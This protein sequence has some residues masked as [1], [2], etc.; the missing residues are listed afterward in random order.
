[1]T[2]RSCARP[3]RRCA[4][5]LGLLSL[6][7]FAP[8]A[9]GSDAPGSLPPHR[10]SASPTPT[11]AGV[12]ASI[13][14]AKCESCHRP[15]QVAPFSL[16]TYKQA[17]AWARD[18]KTYTQSRTMPPWKPVVGY[19]HFADEKELNLTDAERATIAR[20][21]DAGAPPG[22]PA[23]IPPPR[24]FASGWFL[25]EPDVVLTPDRP[26][27]VAADGEDVYRNFI[28]PTN[29][30]EGRYVT[31]AEIQ[32]S[33]RSIVHHCILYVDAMGL[34]K[35]MKASD[36][37]E[38]GY[39]SFG[40]PGFLPTG[41]L[42]GWA[43][44]MNPHW[45]PEGVA[46]YLAKGAAIVLQV[47]YHKNGKPGTD[48]TRI[49]LHFARKPIDKRI[50]PMVLINPAIAI[51]PGESHFVAHATTLI[52]EDSHLVTMM[53]H[54]HFLGREMKIWATLPDGTEKPVIWVR[55]WDFNWQP[56][57]Y[58]NPQ[59]AL[60]AGSHL[61]LVAY[62][63]NSTS[64]PYNPNRASP[65]LVTFGE[66]TTDEMCTGF[67]QVTYDA[68]HLASRSAPPHAASMR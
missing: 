52:P 13:F 36:D 3:W 21:V 45:T 31:A 51:P 41:F 50:H 67:F 53:P 56:T 20:W 62:Y 46:M 17:V 9:R 5:A 30:P 38:P 48:L 6:A 32:P 1:M 14:R 42:G 23:K 22:D 44:G 25:G 19:G 57:Y 64:N 54:M 2:G 34:T 35:M 55:N 40:G 63:D 47:H 49:G 60:P 12:V 29:F 61:S 68:E 8:S 28:I 37:G 58:L 33:N 66:A 26:Y 65:K 7:A 15:G 39:T 18:I 11:Y 16:Q 10:P 27:H 4:A 59:L 43:P 24:H